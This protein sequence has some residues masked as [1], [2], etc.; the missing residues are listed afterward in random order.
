MNT[1]DYTGKILDDKYEVIELI[2]AGGMGT[3]YRGRHLVIEKQVAI[4]FLHGSLTGQSEVVKRFY[5]EAQAAAAVRHNNIIDVMDLGVSPAGEPYIVMEFL[6]GEGLAEYL[7]KHSPLDL[8]TTCGIIEAALLAL[9]AAHAKGIVHRDLKPDNIFLLNRVGEP[10]GIKLI[11]FGIS[12][13]MSKPDQTKLTQDGTMLGTPAYMSPEQARG[14]DVV[15]QRTDLYAIGV[16]LYQMLAGRVPFTGVNYSELLLNMLTTEPVDPVTINPTFPEVA[17]PV[18]EKALK[19]DPKER[20]QS[21]KE[22][23]EAVRELADKEERARHL[24]KLAT[25]MTARTLLQGE[26]KDLG[27]DDTHFAQNIYSEMLKNRETPT[28]KTGAGTVAIAA[29]TTGIRA[30]TRASL[31]VYKYFKTAR[32]PRTIAASGWQLMRKIAHHERRIVPIAVFGSLAL[33]FAMLPFLCS[34]PE[35]TVSITLKNLPEEA[36]VYY[37]NQKVSGNPFSVSFKKSP[38]ELRVE[39]EG[40]RPFSQKVVPTEDRTVA[41][42]LKEEKRPVAESKKQTPSTPKAKSE[43][44]SAPQKEKTKSAEDETEDDN[45]TKK[46]KRRRFRWKNPFRRTK[47]APAK[48]TE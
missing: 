29:V 36:V 19:K 26:T 25:E 1:V 3:V 27:T 23:L 28:S 34:E 22:M 47:K 42:V 4:K 6:E 40:K 24:N 11:D 12:K 18:I 8:A 17:R 9:E 2:G 48:K 21:A 44:S 5:R 37:D 43:P 13:F 38:S 16:I 45:D 10:L 33:L 20:Y 15:D 31:V 14:L 39:A 32:W 7:E 30:I 41:V 35:P 46:T